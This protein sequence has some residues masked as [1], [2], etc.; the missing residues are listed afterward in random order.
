[1][2][3]A[4]FNS[5]L[6][7]QATNLFNQRQEVGL[8][9]LPEANLANSNLTNYGGLTFA[10]NDPM[11]IEKGNQINNPSNTGWG[12]NKHVKGSAITSLGKAIGLPAFAA[13]GLGIAFSPLT[14]LAAL[15]NAIQNSTWGRSKTIAGYLAAKRAEKQAQA[16]IDAGYDPRTGNWSSP[17]GRDHAGTGGIGS[18][19]AGRGG[20]P[21]TSKGEGGWKG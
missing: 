18:A 2:Y 13:T 17:S 12:F 8:R 11:A 4:V 9:Q 3:N 15:N 5:N 19:A 6:A 20:A 16:K 7:N 14:G 1:M 10:P 21:G